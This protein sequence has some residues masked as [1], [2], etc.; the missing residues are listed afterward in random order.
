MMGVGLEMRIKI[1]CWRKSRLAACKIQNLWECHC[2]VASP[3]RLQLPDGE[4]CFVASVAAM[5][6]SQRRPRIMKKQDTISGSHY[7]PCSSPCPNLLS[8][9]VS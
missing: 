8:D 3:R 4:D 7:V 5:T 2:E 1:T 9:L 6:G